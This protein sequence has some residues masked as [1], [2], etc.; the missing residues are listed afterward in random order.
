M[1]TEQLHSLNSRWKTEVNAICGILY[2]LG[3]NT[4]LLASHQCQWNAKRYFK[5]EEGLKMMLYS[6]SELFLIS[7]NTLPEKQFI[8]RRERNLWRLALH[9]DQ[10]LRFFH[11]LKITEEFHCLPPCLMKNSF[12]II[13]AN[14]YYKLLPLSGMYH[15][16]SQSW[17]ASAH[18]HLTEL[19]TAFWTDLLYQNYVLWQLE[20]QNN[21]SQANNLVLSHFPFLLCVILAYFFTFL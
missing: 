14:L 9:D 12:Q 10:V 13:I 2:K 8:T 7:H 3:T 11:S 15:S 1:A 16:M 4:G 17:F 18:F 19:C 6:M 5:R 20:S 21:F